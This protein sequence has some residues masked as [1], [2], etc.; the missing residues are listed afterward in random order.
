MVALC[1]TGLRI[2]GNNHWK[3]RMRWTIRCC[4]AQSL[5]RVGIEI[6]INEGYEVVSKAGKG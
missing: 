4:R 5:G 2:D 3:L 1:S 6:Q